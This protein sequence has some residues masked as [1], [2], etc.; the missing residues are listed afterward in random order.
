[1]H[2]DNIMA[3]CKVHR[4]LEKVQICHSARRV[5]G[6]IKPHQL[7]LLSN[8]RWNSIKIWQEGILLA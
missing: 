7:S 3:H 1:M 6:V 2:D 4:F 5:I 8:F